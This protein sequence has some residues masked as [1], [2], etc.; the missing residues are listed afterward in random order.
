MILSRQVSGVRSGYTETWSNHIQQSSNLHWSHRSIW[1]TDWGMHRAAVSDIR[2]HHFGFTRW[3]YR[4]KRW[5]RSAESRGGGGGRRAP[6]RRDLNNCYQLAKTQREWPDSGAWLLCGWTV[7]D[8][9]SWIFPSTAFHPFRIFWLTLMEQFGDNPK[10]KW[11]LRAK[12]K[13]R[14]VQDF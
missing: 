12:S 5:M 14:K 6:L 13:V 1:P 3:E 7:E 4:P 10:D 8:K 2:R 9:A 11:Q